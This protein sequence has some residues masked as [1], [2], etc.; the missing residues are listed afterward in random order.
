M[1][2]SQALLT[3]TTL[4]LATAAQ[5]QTAEVSTVA[6]NPVL[7]AWTPAQSGG[8]SVNNYIY[9][10]GTSENATKIWS[11]VGTW[12]V[13]CW[14]NEFDAVGGSDTITK[15]SVAFGSGMFPN[16][17]PTIGA[18]CNVGIWSDPNQDGNPNDGI[19]IGQQAGTITVL[20]D[21]FQ[22]F[23]LTT[24][25]SVT[26]KFFAGAWMANA[27]TTPLGGTN[28]EYNAAIDQ[29]S[30]PNNR[31]W[32]CGTGG[33]T[34]APNAFNPASLAALPFFPTNAPITQGT[35]LVRAEGDT[36]F[37][38][39]C[40]SKITANSCS[41]SIGATGLASATAGSGFI[42]TGTTFI[43][44]KSCLLFYG[45]TGQAATTF[46]GGVLCVKT[47]IKRTP[48]TNTFGNPPPNDC[49]GAPAI[50]MNLF[51]VGGGGGTPLPAL[52]VPGTVVNCQWWGR[53]PGFPA[54]NNTQLSNGLEYTVGA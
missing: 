14:M 41:P 8:Y 51:A 35:F 29:T 42:V 36:L 54:P 49:S 11:G 12:G 4:A 26:G 47:P 50:D 3:L 40:T 33:T 48:G 53:D 5:A 30:G 27:P 19:M 31:A 15:I 46:Q 45:T 21:A 32:L 25:V 10:D 43:N 16:N 28:G 1:N 52:Q 37:S 38:T 23:T 9:D 13:S 17:Q 34:T 18:V 22:T 7:R 2:R 24:P 39:Y 6:P 44:N 20:G